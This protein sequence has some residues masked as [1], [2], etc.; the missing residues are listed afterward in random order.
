MNKIEFIPSTEFPDELNNAQNRFSVDVLIYSQAKDEH[1]VGWFD[2]QEMKWEFLCR[3]ELSPF[4]WRY[5]TDEHDR[6]EKEK[7]IN[8]PKKS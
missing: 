3:E 2:F 5:F 6:F 8:K 1:T 7:R 4:K